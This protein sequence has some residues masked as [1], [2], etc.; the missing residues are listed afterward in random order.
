MYHELFLRNFNQHLNYQLMIFWILFLLFL[1]S[2]VVISCLKSFMRRQGFK[3]SFESYL[4]FFENS[5]KV[6]HSSMNSFQ[7]SYLKFLRVYLKFSMNAY[8]WQRRLSKLRLFQKWSILLNVMQPWYS[9][10]FTF[11]D[12]KDYL[13]PS[14]LVHELFLMLGV[15]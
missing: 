10:S 9:F 13:G 7:I 14:I 12:W 3:I 1:I 2:L 4:K 6:S 8:A 5:V 11:F 15:A